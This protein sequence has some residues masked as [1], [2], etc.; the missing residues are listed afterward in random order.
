VKKKLGVYRCGVCGQMV[1][2]LKVGGGQLVCCEQPMEHLAENVEDAS[3]EKH[4]PVVEKTADGYLIKVGSAVHP[5]E[6]DHYI[7]WV[8][9]VVDGNSYLQFLAP[10]DEPQAFFP[11]DGREIF[12]RAYCNLHGLWKASV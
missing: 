5:M 3:H 11:V 9:L 7:E 4:V 10:G 2:V 6:P 12:G 8:E 1:Q